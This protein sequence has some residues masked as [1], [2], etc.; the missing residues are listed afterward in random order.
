[1]LDIF[2]KFIDYIL[3]PHPSVLAL[4]QEKSDNFIRFFAPQK[5]GNCFTLSEYHNKLINSAIIANKFH[6]DRHASKLLAVL[7]DQWLYTLP[8]KQTVFIPIPLSKQREKERGYNQVLNILQA[9]ET[10]ENVSIIN[11]LH[12]AKDTTPQT[13]LNRQERLN[14]MTNVFVF[15]SANLTLQDKRLV[16]VDDVVTTGTTMR[17]AYQVLSEN[18]PKDT[19]IICLALAH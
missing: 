11:L 4:R 1:M 14:N 13:K 6:N 7:L 2:N 15:S 16:L 12:K 8:K 5:Y 9:M 17:S 10:R 18:V 19:E 3:P